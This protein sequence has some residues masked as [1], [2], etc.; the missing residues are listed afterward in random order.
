MTKPFTPSVNID[1]EHINEAGDVITETIAIT[2]G[3][4]VS[5]DISNF[6][7]ET[8]LF[9]DIFSNTMMGHVYVLD[10][11]DLINTIPLIGLE[12]LTISFRTPTM[13]ESIRKSFKITSVD[14]RIFT[15][16]D[17]EQAYTISFI[18]MEAYIDNVTPL[19]K[20]FAGTT[21]T[22]VKTI[23]ED[24]LSVK[25]VV[26]SP[27]S[28]ETPLV[29]NG[30]PHGSSVSFVACSWSPLKCINWV[31]NRSFENA[32][33]APSHLFFETNKSFKFMS[34]EGLISQQTLV[35]GVFG[36]YIYAP[37]YSTK[38]LDPSSRFQYSK[39]E[40][41]KQYRAVQSI[42]PF[43][44]FNALDGQ[45]YGYFGGTLITQDHTLKTYQEFVFDYRQRYADFGHLG[46]PAFPRFPTNQARDPRAKHV[47]RT[48][49]YKLHGDMEDPLYEKWMLQRNSLLFEAG[50]D[51]LQI[52]VAGRTDIEVGVIVNFLYPKAID[53]SELSIDEDGLDPYKSGLYLVTAIRHSFKLN[54]HTMFLELMKDSIYK[55]L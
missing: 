21:D 35:G 9:E 27:D 25:R 11:A 43:G 55:A 14:D 30:K 10:A 33:N 17:V 26:E 4:G 32:R 15:K 53:K 41:T 5:F 6:C 38:T 22:V 47:V 24:Y 1:L 34:V 48:K 51:H 50:N 52:E 3:N 42:M 16:T 49:A 40:L 13:Q 31:A 20:K 2:N 12:S 44:H 29:T 8:V 54:K 36:E 45:D 28:K 39:P 18:S 19:S 23:F 46:N 7:V 37:T